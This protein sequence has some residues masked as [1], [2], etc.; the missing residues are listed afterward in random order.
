MSAEVVI[1]SL[2]AARASNEASIRAI[3]AVLAILEPKPATG[4]EM[5]VEPEPEPEGEPS[6]KH[7]GAV[8]V[9]SRD[10]KWLVCGDCGDQSPA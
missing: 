2:R 5:R 6:C 3:D 1:Q 10:G 8:K 7:V 4:A 9:D